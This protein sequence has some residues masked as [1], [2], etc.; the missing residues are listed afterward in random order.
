MC[1]TCSARPEVVAGE[2]SQAAVN[3]FN[4]AGRRQS[5]P[6][7]GRG[8]PRRRPVRSVWR[9]AK[10]L[11]VENLRIF[12]GLRHDAP[13]GGASCG[14][15]TGSRKVLLSPP[16]AGE[17]RACGRG[18]KLAILRVFRLFGAGGI[19]QALSYVCQQRTGKKV[20][21][22]GAKAQR[23]RESRK[24]NEKNCSVSCFRDSH[25]CLRSCLCAF[26]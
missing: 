21:R 1:W 13:R 16:R 11:A 3:H 20:S 18:Q 7:R 23:K 5:P 25:S 15:M 17:A 14:R 8:G 4:A 12:Q 24:C 10:E 9:N 19:K 22:K 2:E 26:M 6:R